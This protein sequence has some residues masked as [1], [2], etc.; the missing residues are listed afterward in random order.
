MNFDTIFIF[1]YHITHP[2]HNQH[3]S[4]KSTYYTTLSR[5]IAI[6]TAD[7]L[8]NEFDITLNLDESNRMNV[9]KTPAKSLAT[10][11]AVVSPEPADSPSVSSGSSVGSLDDTNVVNKQVHVSKHKLD[12]LAGRHLEEPLLKENPGRFVLFPIQDNDVSA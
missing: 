6:M 1:L 4:F 5:I 12:E 7:T 11:A 8:S 10:S 9:N 2:H 3:F